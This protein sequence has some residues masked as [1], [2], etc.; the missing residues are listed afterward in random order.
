MFIDLSKQSDVHPY[1]SDQPLVPVMCPETL[2]Q[3]NEGH[4]CSKLQRLAS[5]INLW[6]KNV[7]GWEI[8]IEIIAFCFQP[9]FLENIHRVVKKVHVKVGTTLTS[10]CLFNMKRQPGVDQ[11]CFEIMQL[12]TLW[13][14]S[15]K[16]L[17]FLDFKSC[18]NK[19]ISL[20]AKLSSLALGCYCIQ[21][22]HSCL[23]CTL[24][25]TSISRI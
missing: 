25:F 7:L 24:V 5:G 3:K 22:T 16:H 1:T 21:H 2:R 4:G 18:T 13:Q 8:H 23:I 6:S 11:L 10:I 19:D 12:Q 9:Y 14:S 20:Y 17:L 15:G